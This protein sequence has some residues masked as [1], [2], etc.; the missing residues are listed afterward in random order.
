MDG[1]PLGGSNGTPGSSTRR[2]GSASVR[3]V[4][5]KQVLSAT[6]THS[7]ADWVIDDAEI[8]SVTV[9]GQVISI[10]KQATNIVYSL[11]DGTGR[12]EARHWVDPS[13]MEEDE[14]DPITEDSYIRVMGTIKSFG[15][16]RYI[17]TSQQRLVK[18]HHELYFHLL[19]AMA[20]KLILERGPP[21]APRQQ[22]GSS[23]IKAEG[24]SAYSAQST[25]V[26]NDQF[27]HLPQMQ[28]AIIRFILSH[29]QTDD[30]VNVGAIARAVGGSANEIS[31]ALDSL[32]DGG[33]IYT[34]LDESHYAVS[35]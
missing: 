16:K 30:G 23:P 12:L 22:P 15:N 14:E 25:A 13:A 9:I 24:A 20:T 2:G 27:S 21:H 18:D 7:E 32:L 5:I 8:G 6:Q 10:Q 19:D 11:D 29:P 33:H 17:N 35:Q 28:Q 1:S 26:T 34:T 31:A 4:T 3:P